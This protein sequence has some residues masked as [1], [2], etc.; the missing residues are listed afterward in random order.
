[1]GAIMKP[2]C[3]VLLTVL[4]GG[5]LAGCAASPFVDRAET[6]TID[7]REDSIRKYGTFAICHAGEDPVSLA[8]VEALAREQCAGY[9]F[10]AL[11]VNTQRYQCRLLVP[12]KTTYRCVDLAMVSEDGVP[13]NPFNAASVRKWKQRQ[14]AA[15]ASGGESS[16]AT[17]PGAPVTAPAANDGF[18]FTPGSWGDAFNDPPAK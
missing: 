18:T 8:E 10:D 9:G 5:A 1:M 13:I 17:M 7:K 14:A 4:A 15:G 12:H 16:G 11:R 2:L 3:V 6:I